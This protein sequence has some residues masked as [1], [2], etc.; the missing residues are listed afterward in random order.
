M[1]LA[2]M[3]EGIIGGREGETIEVM[4]RALT[5]M[6]RIASRSWCLREALREV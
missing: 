4:L 3:L 2:E 1:R 6:G 5:L